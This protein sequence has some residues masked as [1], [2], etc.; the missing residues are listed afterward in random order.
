MQTTAGTPA[1]AGT[2]PIAKRPTTVRTSGREGLEQ[3]QGSQQ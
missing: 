2:P 1:E 3:K